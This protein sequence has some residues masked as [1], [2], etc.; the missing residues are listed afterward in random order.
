MPL[1]WQVLGQVA[2]DKSEWAVANIATRP[3]TYRMQVWPMVRGA[4]DSYHPRPERY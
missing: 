1:P 3:G 4:G 2:H